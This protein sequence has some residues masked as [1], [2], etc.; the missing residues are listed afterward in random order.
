M[1]GSL[2][3]SRVDIVEE[4]KTINGQRYTFRPQTAPA[5]IGAH[6]TQ[7]WFHFYLPFLLMPFRI[8]ST[9]ST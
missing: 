4:Q 8:I 9:L 5:N 2:P 1:T 7:Y 3:I 6:G